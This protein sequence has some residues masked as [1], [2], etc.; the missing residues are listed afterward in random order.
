MIR[1]LNISI[2]VGFIAIAAVS[3]GAR[4]PADQVPQ[5]TVLKTIP[6]GGQGEWGFPTI[7]VEARRLY[8]PRTNVVQVIDLDKGTL[9]GTLPDVSKQVCHGVAMA[10]DQKLGFASAGK[11]NNVAAFDPAT[12]KVTAR[13]DS[14]VNPNFTLYD[15]ASKH[16]VVM[17]H[18]SVT[19]IDPADLKAKP[20]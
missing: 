7:D 19:L 20:V 18:V 17:N 16:V 13:I 6:L 2:V 10:P 1:L 15:P 5:L 12:L 8:L 3:I 14:S 4:L 11:D 9:V